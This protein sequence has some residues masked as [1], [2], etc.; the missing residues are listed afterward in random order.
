[1]PSVPPRRKTSK[2][3]VARKKR[4]TKKTT[5]VLHRYP[6]SA[7]EYDTWCDRYVPEKQVVRDWD[8]TT[9]KACLAKRPKPE[10]NPAPRVTHDTTAWGRRG[11]SLGC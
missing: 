9:C 4:K 5:P 1:M 8:R 11:G 10:R 7:Y 6:G 2:T 3:K